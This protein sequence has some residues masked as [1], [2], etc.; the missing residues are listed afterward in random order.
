[1]SPRPTD[2]PAYTDV[3]HMLGFAMSAIL[4]AGEQLSLAH[5]EGNRAK[6]MQYRERARAALREAQLEYLRYRGTPEA[7]K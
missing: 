2:A 5:M 1:M 4:H 6:A 3:H 7:E